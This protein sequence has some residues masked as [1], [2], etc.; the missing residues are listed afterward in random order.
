MIQSNNDE[1]QRRNSEISKSIS[2]IV[3]QNIIIL[4]LLRCLIGV[5]VLKSITAFY[6]VIVI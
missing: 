3:I 6:I 4:H 5:F 2:E 1:E